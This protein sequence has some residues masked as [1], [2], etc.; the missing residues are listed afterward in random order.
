MNDLILRQR[1]QAMRFIC[2]EKDSSIALRSNSVLNGYPVSLLFFALTAV[3]L[4]DTIS[5]EATDRACPLPKHP[6][7]IENIH[8]P[9]KV[10]IPSNLRFCV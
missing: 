7:A 9:G 8:P 3:L 10:D 5:A 6:L 1:S 4:I 2:E